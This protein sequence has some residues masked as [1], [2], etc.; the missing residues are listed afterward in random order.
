MIPP[1]LRATVLAFARRHDLLRPGPLLVAVSGGTD[2]AALLTL[3]AD[4]GPELGLVLHVAHFDHR[5][6]PRAAAADAAFVAGLAAAVSAPFRLGRADRRPTSENDA[7][8]ERYAFLRRAAAQI[9]ATAVATGHTRDDQAETVLLHATRGSGLAGL[10]GMRPSRHGIVRPLLGL[11]RA[12]TVAICVAEGIVPREDPTNRSLRFARNRV[13]RRVLPELER[14]NPQAAGALARLAEAAASASDGSARAAALAL[15]DARDG[16]A[17]LL[18]RLDR[19]DQ[20][21]P[22]AGETALALWWEGVSGRSLSAT[23]RRALSALARATAGSARLDLPGGRALREYRRLVR[24]SPGGASARSAVATV[25]LRAGEPVL[26]EGWTILLSVEPDPGLP[27]RAPAPPSGPLTVRG[28]RPGDRIGPDLRT[29]VQDLFTDAKV[30]AR[31]RDRYPLVTTGDDAVWWVVGLGHAVPA[32]NGRRW[33]GARPPEG[34]TW[35]FADGARSI[36]AP[37]PPRKDERHELR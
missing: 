21:D 2:S 9:G 26:W 19:L 36:E 22:V 17:L 27:L 32:T 14:I 16:D 12:D 25:A 34:V 8:R 30:P 6:R 11:S 35:S 31:I 28:R 23:N 13:R 33:L 5:T 4:L 15:D 20:L 7:R 1:P 18:D 3:L 10:A 24:V 29:K 37:D